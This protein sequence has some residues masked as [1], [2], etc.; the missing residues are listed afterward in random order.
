MKAETAAVRVKN[1][2]GQQMIHVD[3]HRGQHDQ[4]RLHPVFFPEQPRYQKRHQQVAGIMNEM[5]HDIRDSFHLSSGSFTFCQ[6][7]LEVQSQYLADRA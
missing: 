6:V 7:Q 4:P 2:V 1:R 3:Q 5:P